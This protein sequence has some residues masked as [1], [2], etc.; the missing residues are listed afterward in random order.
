MSANA[1]TWLERSL[2]DRVETRSVGGQVILPAL[3]V[4]KLKVV[5]DTNQDRLVLKAGELQ[6]PVGNQDAAGAIHID[7]FGLGEIEPSEDS[8]LGVGR[9]GTGRASRLTPP[10]WPAYKATGTGQVPA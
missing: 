8:G 5:P 3:P 9:R 6:Q 1:S 7:R 4:P 10:G 2:G